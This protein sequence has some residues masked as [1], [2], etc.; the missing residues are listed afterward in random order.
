MEMGIKFP[1]E[2]ENHQSLIFGHYDSRGGATALLGVDNISKGL[3]AYN[4]MWS[5]DPEDDVAFN[6]LQDGSGGYTTLHVI[7]DKLVDGTDVLCGYSSPGYVYYQL[8]H[9]FDYC[10]SKWEDTSHCLLRQMSCAEDKEWSKI[11]ESGQADEYLRNLAPEVK[12]A[13]LG[14]E[15]RLV[16]RDLG[17]DAFGLM[18]S[19]YKEKNQ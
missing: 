13:E 10:G 9:K 1:G 15:F 19:F 18:I 12:S 8:Q 5:W 3:R 7:G 4:E 16:A 11:L 6:D 17:E 14:R 2:S